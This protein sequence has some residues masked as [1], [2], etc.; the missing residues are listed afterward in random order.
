MTV[1][2]FVS[3]GTYNHF[4]LVLWYS[5]KHA[6]SCL[7]CETKYGYPKVILMIGSLW[8][9]LILVWCVADGNAKALQFVQ[10]VQ[11]QAIWNL[12]AEIVK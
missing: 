4:A 6:C 11:T 8:L 5:S 1:G 9:F 2:A 10:H 7:G 12:E 3:E